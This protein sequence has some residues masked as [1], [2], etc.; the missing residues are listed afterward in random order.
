[1]F[2]KKHVAPVAPF[3]VIATPPTLPEEIK[4]F[5]EQGSHRIDGP[6]TMDQAT[7]DIPAFDSDADVWL[8]AI[9]VARCDDDQ[10]FVAVKIL[11]NGKTLVERESPQGPGEKSVSAFAKL[12]VRAGKALQFDVDGADHHAKRMDVIFRAYSSALP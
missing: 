5:R 10:A 8:E 12:R 1:M 7:L 3:T 9:C 6:P 11:Y 2:P 4:I